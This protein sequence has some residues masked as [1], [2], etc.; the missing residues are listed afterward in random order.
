MA[1]SAIWAENR[2]FYEYVDAEAWDWFMDSVLEGDSLRV[3]ITAGS[4]NAS[5]ILRFFRKESE[6][7]DAMLPFP[8]KVVG[9]C[10][11][12][13]SDPEE[14]WQA[15]AHKR[16]MKYLLDY[17]PRLLRLS[18]PELSQQEFSEIWSSHQGVHFRNYMSSAP[19]WC[20]EWKV[21]WTYSDPNSDDGF[22]EISAWNTVKG[23]TKPFNMIVSNP[24]RRWI[25]YR[26]RRL[27]GE[28]SQPAKGG[29][30]REL[31]I[32]HGYRTFGLSFG[33]HP[34]LS[35]G[36]PKSLEHMGGASPVDYYLNQKITGARLAVM[37]LGPRKMDDWD[38][39]RF[40]GPPSEF[41]IQYPK[42]EPQLGEASEKRYLAYQEV[43]HNNGYVIADWIWSVMEKTLKGNPK[44][45]LEGIGSAIAQ[46]ARAL[47]LYHKEQGEGSLAATA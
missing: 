26:L 45:G 5:R 37:G 32:V 36:S 21:P 12:N 41:G 7:I 25:S 19:R 31:Q 44:K 23:S 40:D 11:E 29:R 22:Q 15:N 34:S 17:S 28:I 13:L 30:K 3:L 35:A 27:T 39:W 43:M 38:L 24:Y 10:T 46:Q 47:W 20:N 18:D 2:R 33:F 8:V 9:V 16:V 6:I 42:S 1:R 14:A 4:R